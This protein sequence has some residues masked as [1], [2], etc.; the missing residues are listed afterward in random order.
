MTRPAYMSRETRWL[1][2]VE[3]AEHIGVSVRTL[4]SMWKAGRIPPPVKLSQRR[5]AYEQAALDDALRG[6]SDADRD[7]I[8]AAIH[9]GKAPPAAQVRAG[10]SR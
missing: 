2:I 9:A 7:P 10:R 8:M 3:A 4:R 5:L 1:S 6:A